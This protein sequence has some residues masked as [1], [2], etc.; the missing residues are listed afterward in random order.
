MLG[1]VDVHFQ[2]SSAE[3]G[4]HLPVRALV[5]K[6]ELAFELVDDIP[7]MEYGKRPPGKCCVRS[8]LGRAFSKGG[9]A[10]NRAVFIISGRRGLGEGEVHRGACLAD[11]ALCFCA[12]CTRLPQ[13]WITPCELLRRFEG[14]EPGH[15]LLDVI[16][17]QILIA[18]ALEPLAAAESR[19]E[20]ADAPEDEDDEQDRQY[21]ADDR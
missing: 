2:A 9:P 6:A 21:K 8:K 4:G 18:H 5:L 3:V 12:A 7:Q 14:L 11:L 15:R 13:G 16:G 19:P 10:R 17:D 1:P 20:R